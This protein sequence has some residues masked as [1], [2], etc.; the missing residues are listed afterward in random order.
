[1]TSYDKADNPD[2]I[3]DFT[4]FMMW[5]EVEANV[6]MLVCCMPTLSPVVA[7]LYGG[8]THSLRYVLARRWRLLSHERGGSKEG[9]AGKNLHASEVLPNPPTASYDYRNPWHGTFGSV[10]SA[11][12]NDLESQPYNEDGIL[13]RTEILRTSEPK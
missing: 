5:S 6:A 8:V 2:F 9:L 7:K 11:G 3:A 12:Y 1:M 13:T 4:L 10:T